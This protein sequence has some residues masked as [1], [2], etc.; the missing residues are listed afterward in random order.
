MIKGVNNLL[1]WQTLFNQ[2]KMGN[3]AKN[4]TYNIILFYV[5]GMCKYYDNTYVSKVS[6][7][8]IVTR[9]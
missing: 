9:I 8:N 4:I 3:P 1:I 5:L 7:K 6:E 2:V